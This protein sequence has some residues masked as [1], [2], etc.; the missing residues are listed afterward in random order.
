MTKEEDICECGHTKAEHENT[1]QDLPHPLQS[2]RGGDIA[3]GTHRGA[4]RCRVCTDCLKFRPR[5]LSTR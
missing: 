4:T 3:A 1:T 5:L 2:G